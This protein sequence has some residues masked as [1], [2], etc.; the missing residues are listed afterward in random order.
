MTY[1][2]I[3]EERAE[4]AR[5]GEE[6]V[7]EL[8]RAFKV[9]RLYDPGHP[10]RRESEAS[11]AARITALLDAEGS[12]ELA[13]ESDRLLQDGKVVYEQGEGR[14]SLAYL[15]HREG[16]RALALYPGLTGAE[17]GIFLDEVAAAALADGEESFDLIARLW[18]RNFVHIRYSFVETLMDEEWAPLTAAEEG[19]ETWEGQEQ[20]SAPLVLGRDESPVVIKEADVRATDLL[21]EADPTLYYLDDEDMAILQRELESEKDRS[22]LEE[23]L[24]C[25]RE[26]LA[27]PDNDDPTPVLS[28]VNDVQSEYFTEGSYGEVAS[29]Y[30]IFDPDAMGG[31]L[32]EGARAALMEMRERTLDP[33]PLQQLA[34]R[35]DAGV[36]EDAEA[37]LYY[38][39]FGR[40]RIAL[41]LAHCGDLKRLCQRQPIAEAFL[42]LAREDT[43]GMRAAIVDPDPLVACPAAYLAGIAAHPLLLEPLSRALSSPD[44]QVR[45]EALNAVK[46]IGGPR[47]LEIVARAVEDEDPTIRLYALRHLIAHRYAPA[48]SRVAGLLDRGGS[49]SLTE[50]RLLYEAYG[51]L[52]GDSVVEE[53]G[54][55]LQRKGMFRKA[56][57]EETA[58]VLVALGAT[59]SAR[60]RELVGEAASAKHP[61][62]QRT[63]AEI[64]DGWGGAAVMARR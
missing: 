49:R 9:R 46:L 55:R 4:R 27:N 47:S 60:A 28:A 19:R 52:G 44:P 30:A 33:A 57:P 63:A 43:P 59:G 64:L 39:T 51:A 54:R 58:C 20:N 18:E 61:L 7:V 34:A 40:G 50:E 10:Q 26:I 25:L 8:V 42:T 11:T 14:E 31:R 22:L 12:V 1:A 37:A 23:C 3:P 15:L 32:D 35:L 36:V 5:T 21:K 6:L 41:L 45:R 17:L 16:L 48:L 38:A 2:P 56:D 53:L 29:L 62:I 13:I 24:T